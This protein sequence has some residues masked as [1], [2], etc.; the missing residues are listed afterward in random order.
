MNWGLIEH[1]SAEVILKIGDEDGMV[2]ELWIFASLGGGGEDEDYWFDRVGAGSYNLGCVRAAL[3]KLLC[4][5]RCW[6]NEEI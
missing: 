4:A 3:I 1:C 2:P 5:F 6:S